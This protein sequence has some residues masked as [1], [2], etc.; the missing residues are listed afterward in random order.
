[1]RIKDNSSKQYFVT[2]FV[3]GFVCLYENWVALMDVVKFRSVEEI[4]PAGSFCC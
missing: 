1:M 4:Y 2:R 3:N